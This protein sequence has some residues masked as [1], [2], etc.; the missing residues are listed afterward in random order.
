MRR[1]RVVFRNY[2][3]Y[4]IWII[5][6]VCDSIV[7]RSLVHWDLNTGGQSNEAVFEGCRKWQK[8]QKLGYDPS[9]LGLALV[10]LLSLTKV[11]LHIKTGTAIAGNPKIYYANNEIKNISGQIITRGINETI[12]LKITS[13][14]KTDTEEDLTNTQDMKVVTNKGTKLYQ[15]ENKSKRGN[16]GNDR[17]LKFIMN[18]IKVLWVKSKDTVIYLYVYIIYILYIVF[19]LVSSSVQ[20]EDISINGGKISKKAN[21]L[22][23]ARNTGCYSYRR[24]TID[25]QPKSV[26]L[27]EKLNLRCLNKNY[28]TNVRHY[29]T[30]KDKPKLSNTVVKRLIMKNGVLNWPDNKTLSFIDREVFKEQMELVK[31]A[32]SYGTH[33]NEVYQQQI[34]LCKSLYFR[35][36]AVDKLSKS[37]GSRTAGIDNIAFTKKNENIKDYIELVEWLKIIIDNPELYKSDPIR[38]IWIPKSNKSLRPIGI[39]TIRDR[40]LQHLINLILEPLVEMTGEK[41]S[42]GF[43]PNR[44]TKNAIAYLRA[45]LKTMDTK[46]RSNIS[47]A[48]LNNNIVKQ[49][50][51]DKWILDADI[52]GFF[53]NI[54]NNWLIDNL[55][56]N[57]KLKYIIKSWLNSG[58]I[59]NSVFHKTESGT[60]QGGIISPTL[61]NFTLNGLEDVINKALYP[62]TKSKEQRIVIK[63]PDNTKTRIP[64][65]LAYVRYADDFV[66]IARSKYIIDNLVLPAIKAFLLERGLSLNYDKT[67]LFRLKDN[68]KQLD[69]LGYTFKYQDKWRHDK[70]VFYTNHAGARGI[71]LYPNKLKVLAYIDKI[72]RIFYKSQNWDAYNLIAKL[73]PIIRG[74][75][76]Y[77]NM[78]NSSRYR[79]LVRNAIYNLVWKWA[80]RKHRRWGK[81][82]IARNYFLTINKLN[83]KNPNKS[84]YTKIKRVKWVFHGIVKG[85]SRYGGKIKS[86]YLV[87]TVNS[88]QLLSTKHYVLP[89]NLWHVH[90]YHPDYMKVIEFN[91]NNNFKS[92]GLNSSFKERLLKAQDNLCTECKKPLL[93]SIGL[94]E[95]LH[96]HHVT[97]IHRGGKRN[98]INNMVLLHSW[99]H[100]EVD[101]NIRS[102]DKKK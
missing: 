38:R 21:V 26:L 28:L 66:V 87:D 40:A 14:A 16:L 83:E 50:C 63:L 71:A 94:Y 77:Y 34:L 74:W 78:G 6:P 53:D 17:L 20:Q 68:S 56:L 18:N 33:S 59:D 97:P 57:N 19:D 10:V 9:S 84:S 96:I 46:L 22:G 81:K 88:T 42:Y 45:Q 27:G 62:I 5:S 102:V 30:I 43:R 51:E 31:K 67:K 92:M 12:Y 64:Y 89:K 24:R 32:E 7:C 35:I 54:N 8:D 85:D 99:C 69:F 49:M 79:S 95:G 29:S 13:K 11:N 98:D 101:H 61:A 93:S 91:T 23:N 60:P 44:S 58:V 41:H 55:F 65:G 47:D 82:L 76:N 37:T 80:H 73:N 2:H 4:K 15:E 70:H 75:S 52:K 72:R 1:G 39:S 25:Y 100:Y 90:A 36:M 86:I 3:K 48:N